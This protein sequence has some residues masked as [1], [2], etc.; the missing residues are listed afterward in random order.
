MEFVLC[1]NTREEQNN[2]IEFALIH[3]SHLIDSN[4]DALVTMNDDDLYERNRNGA[5]LQGVYII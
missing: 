3:L 4:S 1:I 2:Q 5:H